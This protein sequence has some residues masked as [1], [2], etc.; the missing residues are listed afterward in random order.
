VVVGDL[1]R[2]RAPSPQ[3]GASRRALRKAHA[4][5]SGGCL[6][7]SAAPNY[8]PAFGPHPK[9]PVRS[10]LDQGEHHRGDLE[11]DPDTV[12]PAVSQRTQADLLKA[13]SLATGT[14][15]GGTGLQ[16][17]ATVDTSCRSK[18]THAL[19]S[20]DHA[21][22]PP[23]QARGEARGEGRGEGHAGVAADGGPRPLADEC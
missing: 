1:S 18:N 22:G 13:R 17:R 8:Q 20:V 12:P 23:G 7:S 16:R 10:V 19:R 3:V 15:G 2:L 6:P 11:Q 9:H 4:R 14:V 5:G 21:D